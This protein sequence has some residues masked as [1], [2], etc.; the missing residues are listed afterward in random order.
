MLDVDTL[1]ETFDVVL[2]CGLFHVLSDPARTR[3]ASVMRNVMTPGSTYHLLAFS[4]RVPGDAGPRRVRED[5]IRT[6]FADGFSVDAVGEA[7][8]EA[9]FMDDPVPPWLARITRR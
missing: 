3:L 6:V 5:E 9:T 4:D 8:I 7:Y 1:E 2:D